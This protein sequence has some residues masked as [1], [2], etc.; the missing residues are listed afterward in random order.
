MDPPETDDDLV[1]VLFRFHAETHQK[2]K[3]LALQR[4]LEGTE[5]TMQS[6]LADLIDEARAKD[7]ETR[8]DMHDVV[9][10]LIHAAT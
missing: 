2:L 4:S 3:K 6:M 5:M 8:E 1:G 7:L 10:Q 9:R